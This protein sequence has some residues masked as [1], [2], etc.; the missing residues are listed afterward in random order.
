M[1]RKREAIFV[2]LGILAGLALSGP[3]AHAAANLTAS[4]TSQTFYVNGQKANFE[5]YSIHGN[6]VRFVP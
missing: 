2:G 4:P 1:S 5:A 3:V 6:N